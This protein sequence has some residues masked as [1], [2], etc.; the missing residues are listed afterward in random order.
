MGEN[1]CV[2]TEILTGLKLGQLFKEM[3]EN[4]GQEYFDR[5]KILPLKRASC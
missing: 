4:S 2:Q 3:P 1:F 5:G